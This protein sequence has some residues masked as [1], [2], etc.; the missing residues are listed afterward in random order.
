MNEAQISDIVKGLEE[1]TALMYG[2]CVNCPYM[3]KHNC[4]SALMLD[5]LQLIEQ[6]RRNDGTP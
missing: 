3:P 2:R 5:A 6:L 4:R 1:C